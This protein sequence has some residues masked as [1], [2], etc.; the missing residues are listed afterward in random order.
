M[1]V[2]ELIDI[3]QKLPK[4]SMVVVD[5]YE[6]GV[7]GV[8]CVTNEIIYLDVNKDDSIFGEHEIHDRHSNYGNKYQTADAVHIRCVR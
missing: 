5:G 2:Q 1:N 6:G 3:L 4:S 7:D 8:N